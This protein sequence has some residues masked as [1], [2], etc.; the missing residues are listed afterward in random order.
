MQNRRMQLKH[1]YKYNNTKTKSVERKTSFA[2]KSLKHHILN[3]FDKIVH[4]EKRFIFV[5]AHF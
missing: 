4:I 5:L 1:A 2:N 3:I